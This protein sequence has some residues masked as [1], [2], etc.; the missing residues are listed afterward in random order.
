MKI[1]NTRYSAKLKFKYLLSPTKQL[2]AAYEIALWPSWFSRNLVK[3]NWIANF[4]WR[5]YCL[6][7]DR[8]VELTPRKTLICTGPQMIPKLDRKWSPYWTANDPD[9]KIWN[10]MDGGMV[11]IG[12]WR[13][14][15]PMFLLKPSY[16]YTGLQLAL[17]FILSTKFCC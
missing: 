16:N 12:N 1:Y 7:N 15:I 2:S 17:F 3:I 11:W 8:W 6:H 4:Q 13:T 14:W 9:Q 10:G 5:V